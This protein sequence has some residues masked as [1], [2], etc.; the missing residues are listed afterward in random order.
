[1]RLAYLCGDEDDHDIMFLDPDR[2]PAGEGIRAPQ[3]DQWAPGPVPAVALLAEGWRLECTYCTHH[4]SG[5]GCW[6]C[7]DEGRYL[8]PNQT[9]C[10]KGAN[11]FCDPECEARFEEQRARYRENVA[12]ARVRARIKFEELFPGIP[13]ERI[14]TTLVSTDIISVFGIVTFRVPGGK[15]VSTWHEQDGMAWIAQGD[16]GEWIE[17]KEKK[18]LDRN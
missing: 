8:D 16:L 18:D 15:Y 6:G 11:A 1:M 9:P 7:E 10:A 3:F 17:W 4:V 12:E 2:D 5:D 13:I 14:D